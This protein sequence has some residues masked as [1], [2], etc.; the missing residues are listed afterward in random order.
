MKNPLLTAGIVGVLC[1]ALAAGCYYDKEDTLYPKNST[2]TCD[3]AAVTYTST[4]ASI[5]NTSCAT[6]AC[7][8][9]TAPSGGIDLSSYT[10]VKDFETNSPGMLISS[11]VWDGNASKMPK[12]ATAKIDTCY[13]KQVKVWINQG[14][15]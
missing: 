9:G 6:P 2:A 12:G 10:A 15:K 5:I 7:H 3:T 1:V 13:I 14:M 11:I 4:V 8:A